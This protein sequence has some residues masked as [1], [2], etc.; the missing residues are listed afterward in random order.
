MA[1]I[2]V[3][4]KLFPATILENYPLR[5]SGLQGNYLLQVLINTKVTCHAGQFFKV[6]LT[7]HLNGEKLEIVEDDSDHSTLLIKGLPP[8]NDF[9]GRQPL[10][11]RPYSVGLCEND[12][13]ATKLTFVYKILGPGSKKLSELE[14]GKTVTVLGPLG[15]NGFYLP[16]IK[17][18]VLMVAGGV[19]LPPLLFLSKE[20]L[21]K[22]IQS[23]HLFIGANTSNK[24]PL[25]AEFQEGER[26]KDVNGLPNLFQVLADPRMT[27]RISTDDGSEGY[28][29]LATG[30]LEE[31]LKSVDDFQHT[32][33]YTCGPWKMMA[34][35]A[36]IAREKNIP[37]QACLEE[38]MGCGI[39]AC[40]SCVT[41]IKSS[42]AGEKGW[43]YKLVCRDGPVFDANDVIWEKE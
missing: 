31:H 16:K 14:S 2:K 15:G 34:R 42:S 36:Q 19:G 33:V 28:P 27:I 35:T 24:L 43:E 20:L 30:L 6:D 3:Q 22:G 1:K 10:I 4:Q 12:N 9:L 18:R 5:K 7:E 13:K 23:I 40:Q 39:G 8:S 11:A 41:K 38:M 21:E 32:T 29:G 17:T 37:C 25:H 26:I